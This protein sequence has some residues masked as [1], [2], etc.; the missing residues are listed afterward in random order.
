MQAEEVSEVTPTKEQAIERIKDI[1]KDKSVEHLYLS[2]ERF[3]GDG[4]GYIKMKMHCKD[5]A[6][7]ELM[8]IFN[9]TEEELSNER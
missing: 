8:H 9:I 4:F 2:Q 6:I 7:N 3:T 1:S 5:G